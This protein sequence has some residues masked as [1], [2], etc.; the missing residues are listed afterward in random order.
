MFCIIVCKLCETHPPS[1]FLALSPK[2]LR[3]EFALPV[4]PLV[5]CC[6]RE[7]CATLRRTHYLQ[8]PVSQMS[9]HPCVAVTSKAHP[10]P[11]MRPNRSYP[12]LTA[13]PR[14]AACNRGQRCTACRLGGHNSP[15]EPS[16]R[17]WAEVGLSSR[18]MQPRKE[19]AMAC[20]LHQGSGPLRPATAHH[21]LL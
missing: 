8:H 4:C 7:D 1:L 6:A 15:D 18:G 12:P 10:V 11:Q 17:I 2:C 3:G 20:R 9:T 16:P 5:S 13:A 21:H 19:R 14:R